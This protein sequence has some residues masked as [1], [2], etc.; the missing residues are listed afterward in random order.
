M[1]DDLK[2]TWQ[3]AANI[4]TATSSPRIVKIKDFVFVGGGN[5]MTSI[6]R[7]SI[8]RDKWITLLQCPAY[9]QGLTTLNEELISVG[10]RDRNSQEVTNTVYTF[11]DEE[12]KEVLPPMPTPRMHLFTVSH[13]NEL[14]VAAGGSTDSERDGSKHAIDTVEVYIRNRQWYAIK[15]LP[16]PFKISSTCVMDD[17]C[18]MFG[19]SREAL[20]ISLPNLMETAQQTND[21][22]T[23]GEWKMLRAEQPIFLSSLVELDGKL[24]A[25]GGSYDDEMRVGTIY[26]SFYDSMADTWVGCKRARLPTPL[27]KPGVVK[28]A[29]DKVM[30]IGGQ[31]R[32]QHF[33]NKVYIGTSS[34]VY[35]EINQH[36]AFTK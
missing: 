23:Q 34:R 16:I 7:Y 26:T 3:R 25:M 24:V 17:T 5:H 1:D 19:V 33:S 29:A 11:R 21:P 2:V 6:F 30:I 10:G 22:N 8:I 31:P 28:L 9:H 35:E 12:W 36:A 15:Q 4:P 14:I 32:M 13:N 27:Y 18:Y 20:H